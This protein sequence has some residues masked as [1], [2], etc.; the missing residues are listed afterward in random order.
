MKC[1]RDEKVMMVTISHMPQIL[2][3]L[4]AN[5]GMW[6]SSF[7]LLLLLLLDYSCRCLSHSHPYLF[8]MRINLLFVQ[9]TVGI[10]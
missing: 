6:F 2:I 7:L 10:E 4:F 5:P 8:S 1:I 3:F 9:C